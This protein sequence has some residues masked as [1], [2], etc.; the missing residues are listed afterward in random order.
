ME[1]FSL[2][3]CDV[4]DDVVLAAIACFPNLKLLRLAHDFITDA[5]LLVIA[6]SCPH[7]RLISLYDQAIITDAA[8]EVLA[9]CCAA[10]T[11]VDIG[12]CTALTDRSVVALATHC[13]HL[14]RLYLEGNKVLTDLSLAAVCQYNSA[15]LDVLNV[16]GCPLITANAIANMLEICTNLTVLY[17]GDFPTDNLL[18]IIEKCVNVE[19]LLVKRAEPQGLLAVAKHC[20][21]LRDFRISHCDYSAEEKEA[22]VTLIAS[23]P[24]LETLVL[25]EDFSRSAPLMKL[26]RSL[27]QTKL[28]IFDDIALVDYK[29][30]AQ[31]DE[32]MSKNTLK[33]HNLHYK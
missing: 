11:V 7:L 32:Y 12:F 21:K 9:Q 28:Q 23:S 14:E 20:R 17:I 4:E 16:V 3:T 2:T 30:E 18:R 15:T 13:L 10:L 1:I 24:Q 27:R 33:T 29:I 5:T 31:E 6:H 22:L 25:P 26:L 8:V 19:K